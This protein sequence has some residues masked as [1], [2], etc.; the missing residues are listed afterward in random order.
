MPFPLT[1]A[2][3][4]YWRSTLLLTAGLLLLWL[5]ISFLAG[6]FA[7]ELNEFTFLGFPLG[8]YLFAQGSVLIYLVLIVVYLFA[9]KRLDRRY[10]VGERR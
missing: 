1:P 9:M 3:R 7:R 6:Y 10:G 4:S 8:F 2:Q 5:L